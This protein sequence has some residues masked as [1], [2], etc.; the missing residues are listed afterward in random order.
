[1]L[2][3]QQMRLKYP[4]GDMTFTNGAI[5]NL[6]TSPPYPTFV[7]STDHQLGGLNGFIAWDADINGQ[8]E[9][10]MAYLAG[11]LI[12]DDDICVVNMELTPLTEGGSQ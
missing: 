8:I 9:V 12:N 1:M 3:S 4:S 7:T 6:L 5:A 11:D 10:Q 2:R